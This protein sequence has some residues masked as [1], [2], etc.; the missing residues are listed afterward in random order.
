MAQIWLH[1]GSPKTGTTSLQGFLNENASRLRLDGRMNF[2]ESARAHI[3]HNQLASGARMGTSGQ[4]LEQICREADTMPDCP[5]VISSEMLFNAFTA[6]KLAATVP[7]EMKSRTKVIAYIRRQ[8]AYLE[9]LYKQLLKNSRIEP[10]RQAFLA[11]ANRRVRYLDTLNA[12]ADAFGRENVVVRPFS[13]D[14]LI[15]GDVVQDFAAQIGLEITPELKLHSGFS[16]KSFSA[17][18][19]ELLATLG[20]RTEFNVREVIRELIAIDHPGTIKSRDVF[21]T[22]ERRALMDQ[23]APEN[24]KLIRRFMP[25]H[26]AFFSAKHLAEDVPP[27]TVEDRLR[28]QIADRAAASEA[29]VIAIGNLQSRR[30]QEAELAAED[31]STKTQP[32]GLEE[33]FMPPSWYQEIYP[34]GDRTGWFTSLGDHAASFVQRSKKQLVVSFDNLSQAGNDAYAREPWAQK[35]CADRNFSHLGIYAQTPTWF[36]DADLI[37]YLEGLRDQGFFKAFKSVAFVGTS[38]GAFGALTF[39]SLAPGATVVAFSP[40]STLNADLVPWETR[41][42]KGRAADWSLP[43]SDASMHLSSAKK[44]YLIYDPFHAADRAQ[45][46]RLRG[47]NLVHLKGFGLGHK[48]ALVLNRMDVLKLA[49]EKGIAGKLSEAEFYSAI[50]GRKDIYLYRQSMEGYLRGTGQDARADRFVQAFKKRRRLQNTDEA[51]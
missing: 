8:D 22:A 49:M 17:E 25:D 39:S 35:F 41:F 29:V 18:M 43:Y 19:S 51:A 7:E 30:K 10:D 4:L 45:I 20:E 1:I 3:A 15:A 48:S 11:D 6:R 40:Q 44:A 2:V 50:R 36:R 13:S 42:G 46:D 26:K 21:T 23:M 12:Y 31:A 14:D 32:T 38:M 16:N 5:H 24:K 9:A 47:K 37:A 27:K 28:E 34:G 33:E